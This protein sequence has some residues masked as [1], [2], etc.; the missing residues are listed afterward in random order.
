MLAGY[1]GQ[2]DNLTWSMI[3][4]AVKAEQADLHPKMDTKSEEF[5][6]MCGRRASEVFDKT[7]VVDSTFHRSDA[8]RSPQVAAKVF[9]AFMAEPTLTLNVFRAGLFHASELLKSG[10][11]AKAIGV[12]NKTFSV[13]I[14]QAILVAAA[15]AV[16]DAWREKDPGLPWDDD[17]DDDK[18]KA[19]YFERFLHNFVYN[20]FDNLHLENN[21][22][23]VKDVTP[24]LNYMISQGAD[25]IGLN[26]TLR[27]VMGWDQDYLYSQNNLVFAG[28]ENTANGVAQFFKKLEKG[29]D[30]KDYNTGEPK[31]WYDII[32]KIA[33]G[34]GT[35]TG[36]PLGT[37]M[38]D[39]KPIIKRLIPEVYA[40]DFD[41]MNR[42]FSKGDSDGTKADGGDGGGM[43]DKDINAKVDA[44]RDSLS[45]EFDDDQKKKLTKQY[46]KSLRAST[47]TTEE[48]P[49]EDFDYQMEMRSLKATEKAAGKTGVEKDKV[50]WDVISD[51]YSKYIEDGDMESV[52][53]MKDVYLTHG[54]SE[55]YFDTKVVTKMQSIYKKTIFSETES[56]EENLQKQDMMRRYMLDHGVTAE[57]LSEMCYKTYTASDLK[58]A[59]R[60]GNEKYIMD[61]LIPL[62]R[63]GLSRDDFLK[64]VK[65]QNYGAKTY[66][67]KYSDPKYRQSTGNLVWPTQGQITSE[68]GYRNAPT[69]GASSNHPAIDIGASQGSPVVAAD[70]GKVISAGNAGGYGNQVAIQHDNGM[71]TYYSHLYSWNV[72]VG[73]T[74]AQGQQVGQVGS[75]GISTGPHLD[76]KV[77]VNGEPVNPLE[78]LSR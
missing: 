58:A 56:D 10:D 29:D 4:Q 50:L 22:Y 62:V 73:D 5:L 70:G 2:L 44:Y 19:G 57:E 36:I 71:V 3:W 75:T 43:S 69:A 26:P 18:E 60:M 7:Q 37:L 27:A 64:L 46:E 51:G 68:F 59:L 63:A 41:F 9:T 65:Y 40:A 55:A 77:E 39:A 13:I 15:Q 6:N 45:D 54:G 25:Y 12:L 53:A 48:K 42:I 28:L 34:V 72:K 67:G 23:L 32:Q 30:Y 47:G 24:Y 17:D 8:M 11:K 1:Y 31:K 49:E 38:R 21:M 35:F 33:S 20:V 61:E 52:Q 66:D 78:Y 14:A 16:A 76:F 74:V